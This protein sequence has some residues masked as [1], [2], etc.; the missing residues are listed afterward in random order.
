MNISYSIH[1]FLYLPY[2]DQ[3]YLKMLILVSETKY[4][5]N[6]IMKREVKKVLDSSLN[7]RK[8]RQEDEEM[9]CLFIRQQLVKNN[10]IRKNVCARQ[11]CYLEVCCHIV[12]YCNA[13]NTTL[14]LYSQNCPLPQC[15]NTGCTLGSRH[16]GGSGNTG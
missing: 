2:H 11:V 7:P 15:S 12:Q 9:S 3:K 13:H 10:P 16:S 14:L 5:T 6:T 8:Q 1:V 4:V